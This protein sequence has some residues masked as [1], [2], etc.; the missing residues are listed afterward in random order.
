MESMCLLGTV[1]LVRLSN[2]IGHHH[3]HFV[4]HS[5]F[6][7]LCISASSKNSASDRR[8]DQRNAVESKDKSEPPCV[9]PRGNQ[10]ML[11]NSEFKISFCAPVTWLR[12]PKVSWC[13]VWELWFSTVGT[14]VSLVRFGD[15][16]VCTFGKNQAEA[17]RVYSVKYRRQKGK[18]FCQ[19]LNRWCHEA[20][21][22]HSSV[23]PNWRCFRMF[24]DHAGKGWYTRLRD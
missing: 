3:P 20:G 24:A 6:H 5:D 13:T 1:K 18:R 22:Y 2:Q 4:F 17:S 14:I 8:R 19:K 21:A 15:Y 12:H 16:S 9:C 10:Q 11:S 23:S 7:L